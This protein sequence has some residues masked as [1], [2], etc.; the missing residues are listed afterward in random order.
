MHTRKLVLL[1]SLALSTQ[2]HAATEFP[3]GLVPV[4]LVRQFT[5][6]AVYRSL[7]DNFPVVALPAGTDVRLLGSMQRG[8]T[9]DAILT[10]QNV[11][12]LY[13]AL[14]TAYTAAGWI[15]LSS[16]PAAQ[17]SQLCHD[18]LGLLFIT[19][20]TPDYEGLRLTHSAIAF[21]PDPTCAA[22]ANHSSSSWLNYF[23]GLL[24]ALTP[25]PQASSADT[26]PPYL[27]SI[28]SARISSNRDAIVLT[29]DREIDVPNINIAG[30]YAHYA[31]R[32]GE[33]DWVIDSEDT[34]VR[35]ATAVMF[36]TAAPPADVTAGD[37]QLTGVLTIV[38][39]GDIRYRVTLSVEATTDADVDING[40]FGVPYNVMGNGLPPLNDP[41][42]GIRGIPSGYTGR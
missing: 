17:Y 21:S 8:S 13:Q 6:G 15:S 12:A 28:S 27:I 14:V 26:M 2:L 36:K 10:T 3:D 39:T 19:R 29:Y 42:I 33:E 4:E 7:P 31:A 1:A 30:L 5:S 24:P 22:L 25:P 35:S 34:G 9:H 38:H 37:T 41:A 23:F 20:P 18:D 16:S 11:G 40:L 32:V